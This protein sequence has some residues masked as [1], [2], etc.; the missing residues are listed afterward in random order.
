MDRH[1]SR[2]QPT[3]ATARDGRPAEARPSGA[4]SDGDPRWRTT[5]ATM[6]VA[7]LLCIMGFSFVMPFIPFYIRD[8]GVDD[9]RMVPI[10]AGFLGTGAGLTMGIMGPIWGWVADRYGRKPMV[11]RAMFGGAIILT[12]MAFVRNVHELLVLRIIQGAITGTVPATVALI[13]SVV[14]KA[15]LGFNLGLMQMAVFSGGSIGP[16]VGGI[17]ADHFGYRVPFG[18]TGGLLFSGGLLV[19]FGVKERFVPP[20]LSQR[21]RS[22]PVLSVLR[23]RGLQVLLLVYFLMSLSASFA[24]PIFPLFVEQIV[25]TP[26]RAASETGLLLAITGIAAAFASVM[27]GRHSDR[28]GYKTML[29]ICTVIAGVMCLPHAAAQTVWHLIVLRIFFGF[30]VGGM[31]PSMNALVATI[32]PR[33]N[34]GQAYGF[35]TT[36]SALGWAVG[37]T[38]GG[39]VAAVLGYRIP[40]LI[41][42]GLVLLVSLAQ[43]RW[44]V[45]P[46]A[47]ST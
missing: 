7:Q 34:V 32:V 11:Q 19:L 41:M 31:M 13:S 12:L 37:P 10:W 22:A 28:I 36:A 45:V 16:Y 17:V 40:F 43:H 21:A 1:E 5:L 14:P 3:S 30:G 35:T 25:G 2:E 39:L 38:L 24:M 42:G 4:P 47:Q 6:F 46:R 33:E 18:V 29:V 9:P 26:G 23:T 44:L 27:V 15:R 20:D 8:L